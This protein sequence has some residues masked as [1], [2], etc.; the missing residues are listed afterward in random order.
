MPGNS[1]PSTASFHKSNNSFSCKSIHLKINFN[2]LLGI[3][4]FTNPVFMFI[5]TVLPEY[6]A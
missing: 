4:P 2:A 6:S 5:E 1:F 3:L